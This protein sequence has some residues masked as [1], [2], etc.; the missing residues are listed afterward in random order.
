MLN[1]LAIKL[2]RFL[3]SRSLTWEGEGGGD[4]IFCNLQKTGRLN[5]FFRANLGMGGKDK[6]FVESLQ[7]NDDLSLKLGDY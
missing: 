4:E 2:N 7:K 1:L 5:Q 6:F 3:C